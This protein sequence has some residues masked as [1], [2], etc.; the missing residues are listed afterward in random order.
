MKGTWSFLLPVFPAGSSR[1][2]PHNN[3]PKLR[4]VVDR[5]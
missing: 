2:V 3:A 4:C 5:L 1:S